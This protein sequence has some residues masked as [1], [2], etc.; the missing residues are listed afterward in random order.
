MSTTVGTGGVD[1]TPG[2]RRVAIEPLRS[3]RPDWHRTKS[4]ICPECAS[5]ELCLRTRGET[6]RRG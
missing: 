4:A 6:A 3:Q 2:Q 1:G 5:T